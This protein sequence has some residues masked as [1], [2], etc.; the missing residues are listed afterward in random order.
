MALSMAEKTFLDA[1][2]AAVS[3]EKRSL[4]IESVA[5]LKRLY[6]ISYA[7]RCAG[8]VYCALCE[9]FL[10]KTEQEKAVLE[11]FEQSYYK[12]MDI[13]ARQDYIAEEIIAF[14]K[15]QKIRY[16]R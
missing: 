1:V 7:H 6:K 11:Y 8:M 13:S 14:F 16:A 3:G 2:Y 5:E 10:P 4:K 15:S 12:N 9:T